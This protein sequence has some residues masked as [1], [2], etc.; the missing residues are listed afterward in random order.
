LAWDLSEVDNTDDVGTFASLKLDAGGQPRIAYYDNTTTTGKNLKL[1]TYDTGWVI[2]TIDSTGDVGQYAS[3]AL[4]PDDS[5]PLIAYYDLTNTSLKYAELNGTIWLTLTVD[6]PNTVGQ[7]AS[8]ALDADG[9]MRIAYY[10][11][12]SQDLLYISEQ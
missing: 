7:Y 8:L 1:A 10:N 4:D 6:A 2:E 11:A 9:L 3:L 12:S 5:H